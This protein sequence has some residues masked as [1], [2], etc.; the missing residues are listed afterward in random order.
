MFYCWNIKQRIPT[1]QK[2]QK[3]GSI[4]WLEYFYFLLNLFVILIVKFSPC[5][6]PGD[7]SISGVWLTLQNHIFLNFWAS[8][9]IKWLPKWKVN[10]TS[11]IY[12]IIPT[13]LKYCGIFGVDLKLSS[14]CLIGYSSNS[15]VA[16]T[17]LQFRMNIWDI[18]FPFLLLLFFFF[19]N[20]SMKIWHKHMCNF[21]LEPVAQL[22]DVP[23][24][25]H[26][27]VGPPKRTVRLI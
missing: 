20:K 14:S 21:G 23:H 12:I 1:Q 13:Y 26:E 16:D 3:N 5:L 6:K 19:L 15:E 24:C 27:V 17:V 22:A 7:I 10:N 25:N 2:F 4:V 18:I 9:T 11:M 8:L